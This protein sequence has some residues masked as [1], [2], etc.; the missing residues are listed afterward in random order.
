MLTVFHA[1]VTVAL[2]SSARRGTAVYLQ[3]S[4]REFIGTLYLQLSGFYRSQSLRSSRA[5]HVVEVGWLRSR[6]QLLKCNMGWQALQT[7]G[8]LSSPS[9]RYPL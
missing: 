1:E 4:T 7:R 5:T 3:K 6:L 2:V 9:A 8:F